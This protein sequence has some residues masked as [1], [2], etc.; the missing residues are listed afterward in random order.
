MKKWGAGAPQKLELDLDD[1][2]V[3]QVE[4]M[5]R[6]QAGVV[7][8]YHHPGLKPGFVSRH[9]RSGVVVMG[10]CSEQ[11]HWPT[12]A[13]DHYLLPARGEELADPLKHPRKF[14]GGDYCP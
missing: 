5:P 2:R 1:L 14:S 10:Q 13:D 11:P 12:A 3:V 4:Q 7:A 8:L 6:L 9:P